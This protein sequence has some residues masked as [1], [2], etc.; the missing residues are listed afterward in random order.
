MGATRMATVRDTK[1]M[2]RI[3]SMAAALNLRRAM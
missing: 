1:E 3:T 2:T